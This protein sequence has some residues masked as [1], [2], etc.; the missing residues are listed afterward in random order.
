MRIGSLKL[1]FQD[2][3]SF[4]PFG[5]PFWEHSWSILG[6]FSVANF[7]RILVSI[8]GEG[9]REPRRLL[10]RLLVRQWHAKPDPTRPRPQG[11]G[12]LYTLRAN[13]AD[14]DKSFQILSKS[15]QILS[16]SF[17][18]LSDSFEILSNPLKSFPILSKSLKILSDP[19]KILSNPF[20]SFQ[21]LSY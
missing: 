18:I 9:R 1:I 3:S 19:F 2:F 5:E 20:K 14:P 16:E 7:C 10:E 6:E 21:I 13:P 4:F 15:F 17:K 11:A 12:G 8:F